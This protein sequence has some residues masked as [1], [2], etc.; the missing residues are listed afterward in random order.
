M[1]IVTIKR[2][3]ALVLAALA[4]LAQAAPEAAATRALPPDWYP[5][6]VAAGADGALYV[7]S[8]RQGAVARL[9]SAGGAAGIVVAPASNGLANGQGVLVDAARRLLWV[10]SAAFG[11]TSVPLTPSALKSYDLDSGAPRA[12]YPLPPGEG[13]GPGQCNDVAQDAAGTLYVTDAAQPRVLRL[14]SGDAALQ[15][16]AADAAFAAGAQGYTLN[17]IAIDRD[18]IYLSAVA[19]VPYLLRVGVNGDGSAGPAAKI[20]LPRALKNADALRLAGP[21]R[22]VIFESNAF[23]GDGAYGGQITLARLAGRGATLQTIVAGLNEPSSGAVVD[24]RVYFVESKFA[25][26]LRHKDAAPPPDVPFNVQS[27]ALPAD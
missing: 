14:R 1:R 4:A 25:L 12:S 5:E 6:S 20:A 24:G 8:W 19:A 18:Q 27:R 17:G 9:G 16:W 10:C 13:G 7:S 23:G 26:L 3:G 2:A 11:F 15:S 21:D 22:L